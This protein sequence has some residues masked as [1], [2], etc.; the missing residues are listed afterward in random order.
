MKDGFETRRVEEDVSGLHDIGGVD[1]AV[2]GVVGVI[3]SLQ[4]RQEPEQNAL[5]HFQ[6]V[7]QEVALRENRVADCGGG[8]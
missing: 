6:H 8:G 1:V 4:S 7:L 3:T 2:V 5:F